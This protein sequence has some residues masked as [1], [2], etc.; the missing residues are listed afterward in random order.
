[1]F[2]MRFPMP[3]FPIPETGETAY[4]LVCRYAVRSRVSANSAVWTLTTQGSYLPL[5]SAFTSYI[6]QISEV[7]PLGH[8]WKN[9]QKIIR[10]HTTLP[11]FT[12]FNSLEYRQT[13]EQK[14]TEEANSSRRQI[15]FGP[16]NSW[17]SSVS[18]HPRYCP[19]CVEEDLVRLSFP[20]FRREH[21]LPMVAVCW[22]HGCLLVHGCQK[23]GTYPLKRS[24]F[25]LPGKCGCEDGGV[26]LP[27][28]EYLPNSLRDLQWLAHESAFVLNSKLPRESDFYTCLKILI[29]KQGF[30]NGSP[31]SCKRLADAILDRFSHDFLEWTGI[32]IINDKGSA[33]DWIYR[34]LSRNLQQGSR[35]ATLNYLLIIGAIYDS[36][37]S[38]EKEALQLLQYE[39]YAIK[40]S[41]ES[42]IGGANKA[43]IIYFRARFLKFLTQNPEIKSSEF[44]NLTDEAYKFLSRYDT[45]WLSSI[46]PEYKSRKKT[47]Q[48]DWPLLDKQYAEK[49]KSIFDAVDE[50]GKR[51]EWIS[52]RM[53]LKKIGLQNTFRHH[54]GQL[55]LVTDELMRRT[56]DREVYLIK[57]F[58]WTLQEIIKE[59]KDIT[60]LSIHRKSGLSA[61]TVQQHEDLVL[62][63]AK[64]LGILTA[65]G[66]YRA[67]NKSAQLELF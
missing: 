27:A 16:M 4:S 67:I 8:P 51:P 23:C 24:P 6:T 11:Y 37:E 35:K 1:M 53:A 60:I 17:C 61:R 39:H 63:A 43:S 29:E 44:T 28:Y 32:R 52:A 2:E 25:N 21:Q 7:M 3:Y 33:A 49:I 5:L 9:V 36:V 20:Y 22:R 14:L 62:K 42:A 26:G 46:L 64:E 58:K 59:V 55:P 50:S 65:D 31:K 66:N 15:S 38:F 57:L 54:P 18:K 40:F 13:W 12:Y 19:K 41:E 45:V 34:F 47:A 48:K 56:E 30:I 10:N